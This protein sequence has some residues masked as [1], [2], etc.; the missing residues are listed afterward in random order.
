VRLLAELAGK[1]ALVM[2]PELEARRN[3]PEMS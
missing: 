2:P 3:D 1:Q